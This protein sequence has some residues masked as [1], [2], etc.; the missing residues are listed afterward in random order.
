MEQH[1]ATPAAEQK[2]YVLSA[3]Y[4]K[5]IAV[6]DEL[7]ALGFQAYVPMQYELR[8]VG[9][10]RERVL[11]PA[12]H[13][14]VFVK[15][16]RQELLDFKHSSRYNPYIFFRSVRHEQGWTP[17]VVRE[18]DMESFIRL[19]SMSEIALRYFKPEELRLSQGQPVRIMDGV[20]KGIVGTVRKLPH[21]RGD[22]LTV[23]IPGISTVAARLKPDYVEPLDAQVARSA[24]VP[25]D[26]ARLTEAAC[27][28]LYDLPDD[29]AHET[30]RALLLGK[31]R[32]LRQA[33]DGC[34][35]FLPA[36]KVAF[37]LAQCLALR[38]LGEDPA[39]AEPWMLQLQS[40][41]P[42]LRSVSLL[43]LRASIYLA[44]WTR[45]EAAARFVADTMGRWTPATY[46]DA[47]RKVVAEQ[48]NAEK[49]FARP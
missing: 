14:L 2:W 29:L 39:A 25:A 3:N 42:R 34:K 6:R 17:I 49:R 12:I 21:R 4:K 44:L 26:V 7:I 31:V 40:V 38:A 9:R 28:L 18:S 33:L 46:T 27:Q 47:Q 20:F 43:R 15:A 48:R 30:A 35:T 13:E 45:D 32:T 16:T 5:E 24:D 23:E 8:K 22:Y 10:S 1:E 36:D 19:T 41:T 37:A 11:R